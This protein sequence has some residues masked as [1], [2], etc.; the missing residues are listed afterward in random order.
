MLSCVVYGRR[1]LLFVAIQED[2]S[3]LGTNRERMYRP[4][5]I[6][7]NEVTA[8]PCAVSKETN[9][10][11]SMP[12]QG[13]LPKKLKGQHLREEVRTFAEEPH[14][15]EPTLTDVPPDEKLNKCTMHTN[16]DYLEYIILPLLHSNGRA[17][18]HQQKISAKRQRLATLLQPCA[19]LPPREEEYGFFPEARAST[20]VTT[21]GH[22]PGRF[23]CRV[24][25]PTYIRRSIPDSTCRNI[26][27]AAPIRRHKCTPC[28]CLVSTAK[29]AQKFVNQ[30]SHHCAPF[31]NGRYG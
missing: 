20:Q 21:F 30:F 5:R 2:S 24:K 18:V 1:S 13:L 9:H 31:A 22:T 25:G 10:S 12:F 4:K 15:S 6:K 14:R 26:Y 17:A 23:W 28:C 3:I 16:Q 11:W 29:V 19:S 7:K 8:V 27:H